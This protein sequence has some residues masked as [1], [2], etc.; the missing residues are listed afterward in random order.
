MFFVD[1]HEDGPLQ[2]SLFHHHPEKEDKLLGFIQI[3]VK[4]FQ[5]YLLVKSNIFHKIKNCGNAVEWYNLI[6]Q[7]PAKILLEFYIENGNTI[8]QSISTSFKNLDLIKKEVEKQGNILQ[9]SNGENTSDSKSP[10]KD[11][12]FYG[13]WK[14]DITQTFDFF[15]SRIQTGE[16]VFNEIDV[17][18]F[19]VL[20]VPGLYLTCEFSCS[21]K[22]V[23]LYSGK[24]P[25]NMQALEVVIL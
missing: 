23:G 11:S 16:N 5:F 8:P 14:E 22:F 2:I 20:F 25:G 12:K 17:D 13:G 24:I 6:S 21:E 19:V 15:Y 18:N 10:R 3:E 4:H 1:N 7:V 9:S